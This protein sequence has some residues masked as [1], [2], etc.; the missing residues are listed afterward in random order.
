MSSW[1][2]LFLFRLVFMTCFL[3]SQVYIWLSILPSRVC[4]TQ[5]SFLLC[6]VFKSVIFYFVL[7]VLAF[8]LQFLQ[9]IHQERLQRW[10]TPLIMAAVDSIL[11][12]V[13]IPQIIF[14]TISCTGCTGDYICILSSS[15]CQH[16][17]YL[18]D[19]I[20]NNIMYWLN[21]LEESTGGYYNIQIL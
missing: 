13:D 2:V 19:N 15:V 1:S 17:R 14:V 4:I 21:L 9:E 8:I 20:C 7:R 10:E 11:S 5:S 6:Y 16:W 3:S 18:F 12:W